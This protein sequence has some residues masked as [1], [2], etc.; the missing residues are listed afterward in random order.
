MFF[1]LTLKGKVFIHYYTLIKK[2]KTFQSVYT[3]YLTE[4]TQ[5]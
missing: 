3:L 1:Q 4:I 2:K 5:L